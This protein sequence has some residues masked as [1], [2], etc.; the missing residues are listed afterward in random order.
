M[1]TRAFRELVLI[2]HAKSSRDDPALDDF[3]RPLSARGKRDAP[4]MGERLR[5]RGCIPDLFLSSPAKRARKT[6]RRIA[7]ALGYPKGKVGLDAR[8][9]LLGMEELLS[10]VREIPDERGRVV[11]VGHNPDLTEFAEWLSGEN[12]V[13]IPT[14]G[15]VAL[16]IRASAWSAVAANTATLLFFD[17][18]RKSRDG[19]GNVSSAG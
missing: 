5:V 13:N 1:S 18:P 3:D 2:R 19:E 10:L 7:G 14:C 16:R 15:I 8:L 11:L 12:L 9:Y 17:Y 6:A 4:E